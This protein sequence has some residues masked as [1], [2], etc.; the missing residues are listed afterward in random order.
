MGSG[1][2]DGGDLQGNGFLTG[3]NL[4]HPIYQCR[5]RFCQ[6][7]RA[8]SDRPEFYY[9]SSGRSNC[10]AIFWGRPLEGGVSIILF[11][12]KASAHTIYANQYFP[13]R[14]PKKNTRHKIFHI[15]TADSVGY[16]QHGDANNDKEHAVHSHYIREAAR[17]QP[18]V[19]S[20]A[21]LYGSLK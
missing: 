9:N 14:N 17:K 10:P 18:N 8:V 16:Q 15:R 20:S 13:D 3:T 19:W 4:Y 12:E 7:R 2:R 1:G 5:C 6:R 11:P 21:V